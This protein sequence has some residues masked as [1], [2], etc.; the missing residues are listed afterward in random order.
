MVE[1][2]TVG[3]RDTLIIMTSNLSSGCLVGPAGLGVHRGGERARRWGW[4]GRD[5]GAEF[6][7]RVG[8]IILLQRMQKSEDG[9]VV[10]IWILA[11]AGLLEDRK[12]TRRPRWQHLRPWPPGQDLPACSRAPG[13]G[14]G[15]DPLSRIS[16][17]GEVPAAITS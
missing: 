16:S 9:R 4:C 15:A 5:F 6:L 1:G 8:E 14:G 10:E 11:A 3:P 12:V 7:N 2:S 17:R 13:D